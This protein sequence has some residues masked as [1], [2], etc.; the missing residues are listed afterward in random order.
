MLNKRYTAIMRIL[1]V[2][3]CMMLGRH[4]VRLLPSWCVFYSSPSRLS[5]PLEQNTAFSPTYTNYGTRIRVSRYTL[6]A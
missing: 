6:H 3:V 5:L 2:Y 4:P 1:C